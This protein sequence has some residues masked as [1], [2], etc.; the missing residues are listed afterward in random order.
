MVTEVERRHAEAKKA[1]DDESR[2]GRG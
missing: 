2:R 1:A